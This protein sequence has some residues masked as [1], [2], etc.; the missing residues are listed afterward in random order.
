M[1]SCAVSMGT[2]P[3]RPLHTVLYVLT[4]STVVV[5]AMAMQ[6]DIATANLYMQPL[7]WSIKSL[8]KNYVNNEVVKKANIQE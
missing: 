1:A 6:T 7:S 3:P 4:P 8:F 2:T 5:V